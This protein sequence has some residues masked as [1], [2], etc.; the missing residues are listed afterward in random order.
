MTDRIKKQEKS[1]TNNDQNRVLARKG[2]RCLTDEEMQD[3]TGGFNTFVC[4][5]SL[6]PPYVKD[7]DACK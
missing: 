7:G 4:T 2:A 1:M 5:V 3:V 6:E